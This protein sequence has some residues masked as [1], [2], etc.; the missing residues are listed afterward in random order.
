MGH[1]SLTVRAVLTIARPFIDFKKSKFLAESSLDEPLAALKQI[2]EKIEWS[3][4]NFSKINW[5]KIDEN[6]F[7][8]EKC[9]KNLKKDNAKRNNPATV[10]EKGKEKE[11][12]KSKQKKQHAG[13]KSGDIEKIVKHKRFSRS[14]EY[15]KMNQ[16]LLENILNIIVENIEKY[17]VK[18][19]FKIN[20]NTWA[21]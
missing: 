18:A 2:L 6:V 19:D 1:S 12:K 3:K 14:K 10:S 13:E 8:K 15:K 7:H 21:T 9:S 16:Q 20:S 17:N 11:N 5:Q 4:V